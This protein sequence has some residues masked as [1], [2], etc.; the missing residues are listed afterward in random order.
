VPAWPLIGREVE[1][2]RIAGI[3]ASG[4]HN[5]VVLH[6]E[7]GVGKTRL[8]RDAVARAAA[9]G[10][11]TLWAVGTATAASIPLG[12]VAHFVPLP[13]SGPMPS[14]FILLQQ[15]AH[16]LAA[17][18]DGHPLVV[19]IDDAHLLDPLSAVLVQQLALTGGARLVLTVRTGMAVPDALVSLWKDDVLGRFLVEPL[20]REQTSRLVH[21]ALEGP[22]ESVTLGRLWEITEGN[23]LF[24]RHVVEGELEAGRLLDTSGVWRWRGSMAVGAALIELIEARMSGLDPDARL[25]LDHLAFA[26]P[27]GVL[28]LE[29]LV[30]AGAGELKG[31][32][33][34]GLIRTEMANRRFEARLAHP[35]YGEVL[36]SEASS[37]R[38]QRITLA[39]A[40][41]IT[42][43]GLR[44]EGDVL[45]VA[46]LRVASDSDGDPLLLTRAAALAFALFDISLS[47]RLCRAAIA[48]GAGLDA[49]FMLSIALSFLGR[50]EEA[51]EQLQR[52]AQLAETPYDIA[53]TA[54]A[55]V[56]NL[57]WT[58][59]R[60]AESE[61]V[62]HEA[63]IATLGSRPA[64]LE[65]GGVRA[66][67]DF[68]LGR[69]RPALDAAENVL[70][71]PDASD[72]ARV[73]AA[74]AAA[75][76]WARMGASDRACRATAMGIECMRRAPEASVFEGALAWGDLM[77]ELLA[78]RLD[79][80][81]AKADRC[82]QKFVQA[83]PSSASAIG[84]F[85]MGAVALS[86][87]ALT[88]AL[89]WFR[90]VL[91]SPTAHDAAAWKWLGHIYATQAL[92]MA[93]DGEGARR[94]MEES[95]RARHPSLIVYETDD[96]LAQAWVAAAEGVASQARDHVRAAAALA[97]QQG[98][99]AMEVHAWHTLVRM[100]GTTEAG[101][102]LP[103]LLALARVVQGPM[104]PIAVRHAQAV[105][106]GDGYGLDG[107]GSDF[108]S[109]GA[110]LLAADAFAQAATAHRGAGGKSHGTVSA[111]RARA[112]A[113]RCGTI[114]TPALAEVEMPLPITDR[115]REVVHLAASGL[116]N[117]QI[118]QRL[119]VSV[120]TVESHLYQASAKLGVAGREGL[121]EVLGPLAASNGGPKT[122][123]LM[124]PGGIP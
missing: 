45:K 32:E 56:A 7:A 33:R 27:L 96:L 18:A 69:P 9:G 12:A 54:M 25:A 2:E 35:L 49:Q 57:F 55:R 51:D 85:G 65:L 13:Q 107:V 1:L 10:A 103:H 66:A 92:G 74:A 6:G 100:G 87:G 11:V 48:A 19:G 68:H 105:S 101:E 73:W 113:E 14:P 24:L 94:A 38:A 44:R 118:A 50:P 116:S 31:L 109:V 84:A 21:A 90:E 79:D 86:Q 17:E 53:R 102:A 70:A 26:E 98:I 52:A 119:V 71:S 89:S 82:Q 78:G 28:L 47:E 61:Q 122:E 39:V 42:R 104:A 34:R 41:A 43:H 114:R 75:C 111:R 93:G 22:V 120:R 81:A 8:A 58:L 115:E 4:E 29:E 97:A 124:D 64:S 46:S 60:P 91:A 5:G 63:E 16:R 88:A 67:V 62:L 80:A 112:L 76:A 3:V 23:P 99:A 83:P 95:A 30:R 77:G 36:R 117:R 15:A 121:L 37:V 110:H 20:S 123:A 40:Q 106:E 108:E 59:R 72:M